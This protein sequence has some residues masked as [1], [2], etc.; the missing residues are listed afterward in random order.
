LRAGVFLFD[1]YTKDINHWVSKGAM[2]VHLR[3]GI[4][5]KRAERG[6]QNTNH[7]LYRLFYG[8]R[9]QQIFWRFMVPWHTVRLDVVIASSPTDAEAVTQAYAVPLD[10]IPVTGLPRN[11]MLVQDSVSALHDSEIETWLSQ[12][13]CEGRK[14]FLYM[15]TFRDSR[16]AHFPGSLRDF[17][18]Q[19][20]KMGA[21][22]I[23]H[24][25]FADRSGQFDE[26]TQPLK[27]IKAV[28]KIPDAQPLLKRVD[29]LITDYSSVFLDFLLLRRPVIYFVPDL[30]MY[31]QSC[32][33]LWHDYEAVTPGPKAHR[34]TELLEAMRTIVKDRGREQCDAD[35]YQDVLKRFHTYQDGEASR[36]VFET[37]LARQANILV[38]DCGF[39]EERYAFA[40]RKLS[41][42]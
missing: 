42:S 16:R 13:R 25:H 22:L 24:Q 20:G 3:H 41:V 26:V 27:N 31:Q 19:L 21:S 29:C 2:K 7:R 40:T 5:M 28:N 32:R 8:T 12:V 36:R 34:V 17:D 33:S 30:E 4:A 14:V 37:I 23:W 39:G 35:K 6:I 15:P 11:D 9:A 10:S 38:V 18:K 1:G